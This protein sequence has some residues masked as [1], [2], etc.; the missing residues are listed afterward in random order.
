MS[1]IKNFGGNFYG[2]QRIF[3]EITHLCN[4]VITIIYFVIFPILMLKREYISE[5]NFGEK[6]KE[7]RVVDV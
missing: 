1:G 5:K 4:L 3:G 2:I 7:F 6:F